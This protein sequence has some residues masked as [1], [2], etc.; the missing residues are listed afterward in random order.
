M[1]YYMK[2]YQIDRVLIAE[3]LSLICN[4][5]FSVDSNYLEI[6]WKIILMGHSILKLALARDT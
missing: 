6:A 1:V 2:T 4:L 3:M 5:L